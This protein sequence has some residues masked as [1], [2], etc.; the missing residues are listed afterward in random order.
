MTLPVADDRIFDDPAAHAVAKD[1]GSSAGPKEL[2]TLRVNG[3]DST[4]LVGGVAEERVANNGVGLRLE[5]VD[6]KGVPRTH[7]D[8]RSGWSGFREAATVARRRLIQVVLKRAVARLLRLH[9]LGIASFVGRKDIA[10][11]LEGMAAQ[12]LTEEYADQRRKQR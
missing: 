8:E 4:A 5:D 7:G 6:S 2:I 10:A 12:L 3:V 11:V 9:D 1:P